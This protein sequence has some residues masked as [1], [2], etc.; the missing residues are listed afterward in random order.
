MKFATI[1]L[2]LG[3]ISAADF[4]EELINELKIQISKA[5][6]QEIAK[7]AKDVKH[8]LKKIDHSRPVRNLEASLKRWAHTKEV[9]QIEV[10]DKAFWHSKEGQ[11]L[12]KEWKDVGHVLKQHLKHDKKTG[13]LSL[14]NKYMDDLEDEL[15]D[16]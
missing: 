15:E 4:Q 7:E 10:V 9:H 2:F 6:Q 5:G 12:I 14:D 3:T 8:T 1:A 11:R 16:V 13:T